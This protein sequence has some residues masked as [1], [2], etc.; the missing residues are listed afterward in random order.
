MVHCR[1]L[2]RPQT[3]IELFAVVCSDKTGFVSTVLRLCFSR[4]L[5]TSHSYLGCKCSI[6]VC[7]FQSI[8]SAWWSVSVLFQDEGA[9]SFIM[10]QG[11]KKMP[12][13]EVICMGL[14]LI[15]VNIICT[16]K[17]LQQLKKLVDVTCTL[18][19]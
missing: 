10:I 19:I 18:F 9:H 11:T 13:N 16:Q 5:G 15:Q 4:S 12:Q 3:N 17:N 8:V 2:Q 7:V 1:I 14:F 6:L